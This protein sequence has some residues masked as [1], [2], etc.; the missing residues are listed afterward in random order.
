MSIPFE[1]NRQNNSSSS[2]STITYQQTVLKDASE[3]TEF[4]EN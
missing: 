1:R 3:E 2:S 4:L